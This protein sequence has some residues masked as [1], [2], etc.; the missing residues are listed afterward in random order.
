[1]TRARRING[2]LRRVARLCAGLLFALL[3]HL[4]FVQAFSSRSL[5]ADPR[6]E[7]A[8]IARF[9][10]PRGAILSYEGT[11]VATSRETDGGPYRYR[12]SYPHGEMFAP[13]TG[14][15]TAG[16]A[17]GA[18]RAMEAALSGTDAKVKMQ[19]L[20]RVG[21]EQAADVR[22]TISDR[23][24]WA[25]YQSLRT[26]GRPGAAV[27]VNPA[28]GAILALASYPSYD[29]NA[30]ATFDAAALAR[31]EQ[32]LRGAP[33]RPLLNRATAETYPSGSAFKLVTAAAA[34]A[35]GE[36]GPAT[37]LPGPARLR[38]PGT[39]QYVDN[40]HGGPC[41]RAAR[42]P[43]ARAFRISCDTAFAGIGLQLGQDTLR[44]QADAFG[45]NDPGLTIPL[46]VA[47]S[48]YDGDADRARTALSAVG[49]PGGRVTP[50]MVAMLSAA[51]ANH[52]TLMRPYLVEEVRL[53]DG[54]V[55]S[56]AAPAP[57]RTTL[58]PE[59]AGQLGAMMTAI[60]RP[61][62][63]GA[64]AAVPGISVAAQSAGPGAPALFTAFA[65]ARAPEV[66]VG[67]VLERPGPAA[68][69]ARTI[70]QAVLT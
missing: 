2:T 65:P 37:E 14:H 15:L 56:R 47:P 12:R 48:S 31:T 54:S 25:A 44:D 20:V 64:A 21:T 39:T 28:T 50:L 42:R 34:L 52:G 23:A 68:P 1:M 33:G 6:N 27:A 7:R 46:P 35:T 40:A 49:A 16:Q 9:D 3:A 29:P 66:A 4:T 59:L 43:L 36:Y 17:T 70:M 13:V 61:G 55:I 32:R 22:L 58:T 51:V 30:Y 60:T 26:A 67:V 18:E 38:L 11:V 53:R 57:Y 45:F 69:I 8:R 10:E 63:P 24:Q 62:G 19:S 5:N 41:G